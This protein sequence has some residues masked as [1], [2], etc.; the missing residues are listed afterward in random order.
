MGS[1][2]VTVAVELLRTDEC[3]HQIG[4]GQL[5]FELRRCPHDI[6]VHFELRMTANQWSH[7]ARHGDVFIVFQ[8]EL[9]GSLLDTT[10]KRSGILA[11]PSLRLESMD[12]EMYITGELFAGGFSGWSHALRRLCDMGMKF[13]HRFALE[14]EEECIRAYMMSH[15]F[16]HV[17]GPHMFN[18]PDDDLPTHMMIHSDVRDGACMHLLGR[19]AYDM[20]MMSPPCPPWSKA[21]NAMGLMREEGRLTPEAVGLCNLLRPKVILFENVAGMKDHEQWHLIRDMFSWCGYSIRFARNVNLS[22]MT[23]QNRD[24]LI[25]IATQEGVE[26]QPHLC[27]GFPMVARTSLETFDCIM[28]MIEP[29][30]TQT[31]IAKAVLQ[32]YLDAAFMPNGQPKKGG[33]SKRL[34]RDLEAYIGYV[35]RKGNLDASWHPMGIVT[36]SL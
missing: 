13:D 7:V 17:C 18:W 21:T 27:C 5:L 14:V 32:M 9:K 15:N 22:E 12:D 25:L 30:I 1:N 16:K 20:L 23:P 28:P 10:S 3:H 35:F 31:R 6:D 11:V 2:E 34:R 8:A 29:W 36:C 4:F 33:D 24:R 26:L 19:Q